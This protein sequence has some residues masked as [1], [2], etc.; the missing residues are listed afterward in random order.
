[1]PA[2]A[3]QGSCISAVLFNIYNSYIPPLQPSNA[4]DTTVLSSSADPKLVINNLQLQ[5]ET[6]RD[7]FH[8]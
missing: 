1:M 8:K 2:G 4:D 6:L 7:S 3:P 5:L